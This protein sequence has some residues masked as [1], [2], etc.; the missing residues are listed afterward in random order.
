MATK[1]I[2]GEKVGMTQVWDD[3]NRAVPVTVLKVVGVDLTSIGEIEPRSEDDEVLVQEDES[4]LRYG[5]LLISD[6]QI[7]GAILLGYSH[8]V[9]YVTSAVKQ[10]WDVTPVLDALRAGRWDALER[11]GRG[12]SLST[13]SVVGM[14]KTLPASLRS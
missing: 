9:A 14:P 3:Q 4:E 6:G 10:G 2:V 1:A 12:R 7:I 13:I 11:L 8:E 5:K